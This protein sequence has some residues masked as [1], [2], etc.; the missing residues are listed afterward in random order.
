MNENREKKKPKR[1][2]QDF[3][4]SSSRQ[5]AKIMTTLMF[6]MDYRQPESLAGLFLVTRTPADCSQ[7]PFG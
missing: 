5:E 6:M 2:W 3:R 1:L 7:N 4:P